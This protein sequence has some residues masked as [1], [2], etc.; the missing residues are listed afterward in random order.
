[1]PTGTENWEIN[2]GGKRG[3][4]TGPKKTS[5]VRFDRGPAPRYYRMNA[6]YVLTPRLAVIIEINR[7]KERVNQ[8]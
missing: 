3:R 8:A 6:T 7:K 1:M 4:K 5:F 2:N